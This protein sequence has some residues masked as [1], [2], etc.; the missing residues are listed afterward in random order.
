MLFHSLFPHNIQKLVTHE[1]FPLKK[2]YPE[3]SPQIIVKATRQKPYTFPFHMNVGLFH[4]CFTKW[5]V[6]RG[7]KEVVWRHP[8]KRLPGKGINVW[9]IR[10][11]AGIGIWN[12]QVNMKQT[13]EY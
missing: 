7:I 4:H 11:W 8:V 10:E 3:I 1:E 12:K 6:T 5:I 2:H 9:I 13:R